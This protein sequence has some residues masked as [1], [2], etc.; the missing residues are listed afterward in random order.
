MQDSIQ[1]AKNKH[2]SRTHG[3]I[4]RKPLAQALSR[5]TAVGIGL[6][7]LFAVQCAL[8]A[9]PA[10]DCR[11]APDGRGWQCLKDGEPVAD[12]APATAAEITPAASPA[13]PAA[14]PT[15]IPVPE[16]LPESLSDPSQP[17]AS[18]APAPPDVTTPVAPP[19]PATRPPVGSA[20]A[21]AAR[22]PA[23][24]LAIPDDRPAVDAEPLAAPDPQR[25][26]PPAAALAVPTPAT[27]RPP[28]ASA[29]EQPGELPELTA[30]AM[31][32]SPAAPPQAARPEASTTAQTTGQPS[33]QQGTAEQPAAAGIPSA[34]LASIDAGIEWGV[35]TA[36]TGTRPVVTPGARPSQGGPIEIT[37]DTAVAELTPEQAEFSGKVRM[38]QDDL[39]LQAEHL[40]L[41]R[42]SGEVN[43]SG[44]F[45]LTQPDIRFAGHNAAYQLTTRAAQVEQASYRIPAIRARG[46][47]ERA[48]FLGNG[49]SQ[50]DGISYTT[51]APGDSAWLLTADELEL[52]QNEGFGTA[53][54]ASLRFLGVPLL[55]APTFTFPIDNRRRSGVLVPT[56]GYSGNTGV[57]VSVPYYL[58]LAENYDLTLTPRLMS[59]RGLLLGSEFRYLTE[60]SRGTLAVDL[61][62]DDQ[63]RTT[64]SSTRG[65]VSLLSHTRFDARTTADLRVN[66]ISDSDYLDDLGSSLAATSAT[67]LERAGELRYYGDTW[68]LL[69]R[70]QY[71]QTIDDDILLADRPYS[72][73]PQLLIDLEHP[74]GPAGLTYHLD[75]EYANF[76][77]RDSVRGHRVDLAPAISL[78]FGESWWFLK[79][80]VG[81]RYTTYRLTDQTAGLDDSPSHLTG[82]FSLDSGLYYDRGINYFGSAATQTLEPRL[83]Y[84][85][86]PSSDQDDHPLFDTAELDFN[87]DNLFRENRFNGADRIAD[88]NQVTLALTSRIYGE[89]SGEELLRAS[90][91]Q[92]LY[93]ED[94]NVTLPD[95]AKGDDSS[96]AVV[97]EL[98]AQL[99]GGWRSR[100][101]VQWDPHDGSNGTIDQALAQIS[102]RDDRRHVFNAA[103]RLRDGVTRQTDLAFYWPVNERF[104]LIGRHNYSLQD[105]RLLEALAGVEYGKCCWRVR[106]LLRKYT[107]SNGDDHNLAFMLQLEL[108]GLGRLGDDIDSTLERGVYGYRNDDDD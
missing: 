29:F 23:D 68:D 48:A 11:M 89:A 80:K 45:L 103:Y 47:A 6:C 30:P 51:C 43:A 40:T 84:L 32:P 20:V 104:S 108:N 16:P 18:T 13:Q 62:P 44:G 97:A 5:A 1:S 92:I 49:I 75:G 28:T 107:D 58:N 96:S 70:V 36:A 66:Y 15:P 50:F 52:D 106:A 100:A 76:Y 19:A 60:S 91:G 77:R 101:G 74:G 94:R 105:N 72:R 34:Y 24:A 64:G 4:R 17:A 86:V 73:L 39:S 42:R 53:R 22:P 93:F 85:Y 8:A 83:Y 46:D 71:Y 12:Q 82:L 61:L 57:D 63:E 59:K 102:Y 88:A 25:Q 41:N 55:Y 37:A 98:A 54:H 33:V 95:Q 65:A 67:H 81:A 2:V 35:C 90:L 3:I 56:V 78:P 14:T 38:T 79:P 7:G 99:G 10:W 21:P 87:F 26:T 69:G 9:P 27:D 31:Q